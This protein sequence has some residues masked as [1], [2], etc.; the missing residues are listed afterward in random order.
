MR[1]AGKVVPFARGNPTVELLIG[2]YISTISFKASKHISN[3][4]DAEPLPVGFSPQ[5]MSA[6]LAN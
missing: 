2:S 4:S 5:T 3:W 1:K 6:V